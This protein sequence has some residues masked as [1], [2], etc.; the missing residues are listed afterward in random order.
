MHDHAGPFSESDESLGCEPNSRALSECECGPTPGSAE[1]LT[2]HS[3]VGWIQAF[4][5]KVVPRLGASLFLV[6]LV[7]AGGFFSPSHS[8]LALAQSAATLPPTINFGR[9]CFNVLDFGADPT[10]NNAAA[11]T[12]AFR[13]AFSSASITNGAA[14]CAPAGTYLLSGDIT[15]YSP[16]LYGDYQGGPSF[17][18]AGPGLTVLKETSPSGYVFDSCPS[19]NNISAADFATPS[20][21]PT[22]TAY[23]SGAQAVTGVRISGMVL[24]GFSIEHT[25][26]PTGSDFYLPEVSSLLVDNVC[27]SGSNNVFDFGDQLSGPSWGPI[28]IRDSTC[29]YQFTG[30]FIASHGGGGNL[31]V[32]NNRLDAGARGVVLD[33]TDMTIT[34]S[35]STGNMTWTDNVVENPFVGMFLFVAVSPTAPAP[36]I[37]DS[38]WRGNQYDNCILACYYF[39]VDAGA[40]SNPP[41]FGHIT[42]ADRSATSQYDAID[43]NGGYY[44]QGGVE[45]I[46]IGGPSSYTGSSG[47]TASSLLMLRGS[48]ATGDQ[49]WIQWTP[50]SGPYTTYVAP[51]GATTRSVTAG[52]AASITGAP[53]SPVA[54]LIQ[55]ASPNYGLI[56][57]TLPATPAPGSYTAAPYLVLISSGSL[58]P[59]GLPTDSS[60]LCTAP[61]GFVGSVVC[62]D[63]AFDNGDGIA[64]RNS[65]RDI[66]VINS[67]VTSPAGAAIHVW[68]D[69]GDTF[70]FLSDILGQDGQ[71]TSYTGIQLDAPVSTP[72]VDFYI[73][74]N[75]LV[76]ATKGIVNH[77]AGPSFSLG[78]FQGAMR[79]QRG[80]YGTSLTGSTATSPLTLANGGPTDCTYYFDWSQVTSVALTLLYQTQ[81]STPATAA[82]I[83]TSPL[84]S[85]ITLPVG[86]QLKATFMSTGGEVVNYSG[87]CQP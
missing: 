67:R 8:S 74:G 51:S 31:E 24:S 15:L 23:V 18:G 71:T 82:P 66:D 14:V 77:V 72:P 33:T 55:L 43:F 53:P 47:G 87:F 37:Q 25:T 44:S 54:Q 36:G 63:G 39:G 65:A 76:G 40:G 32:T 60:A 35:G 70:H 22:V 45:G 85:Q 46:Q 62:F 30:H 80:A 68:P 79:A 83:T 28:T 59:V 58:R 3:G 61:P 69:G 20:P 64:I 84:P 9:G 81:S 12:A 42:M 4:R 2:K 56:G 57:L 52:L 6:A 21:C 10:G 5:E 48:P 49:I 73:A 41:N 86:A 13:S 26:T 17:Y 16:A 29:A 7:I 50:G 78:S 34:A 27:V 19:F 75:D 11:T 1:F 38:Q